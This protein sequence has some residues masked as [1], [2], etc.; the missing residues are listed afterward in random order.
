[1]QEKA[2]QQMLQEQQKQF[3]V[4]RELEERY[5]KKLK[6][7]KIGFQPSCNWFG[8][9][10]DAL[11]FASPISLGIPPSDLQELI[12]KLDKQER[13]LTYFQFAVLSNNLE[14]RTPKELN[15]NL[16][17]YAKLMLDAHGASTTWNQDTLQ[18]KE[19]AKN[20]FIA[21]NQTK[22]AAINGAA[23]GTTGAFKVVKAEA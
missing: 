3:N 15:L 8:A 12:G 5:F 11:Q 17:E 19:D 14:A 6:E 20:E 7:T 9:A 10:E 2:K 1:M 13:D 23:S 4:A 18:L 21:E 16:D 22:D